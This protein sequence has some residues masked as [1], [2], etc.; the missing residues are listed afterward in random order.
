M[1]T[2]DQD[3]ERTNSRSARSKRSTYN[4]NDE[5]SHRQHPDWRDPPTGRSEW[6][7]SSTS[8]RGAL[9]A[10]GS[11][12]GMAIAGCL[13]TG[14]SPSY[15][16]TDDEEGADTERVPVD[17]DGEGRTAEEMTAA[18]ALADDGPADG[19]SPLD[20]ITLIDHEFVLE[21]GY[22]GSTVQGTLEN[23]GND[24]LALVEIRVR[25][26]DDADDLLG[27]YFRHTNDLDSGSTWAFTVYVLESPADIAA[28]DIAA[29]GTPT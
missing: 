6:P 24:R 18:A 11:I 19:V 17:V 4:T 10:V 16:G 29:L 12:A 21:D 8:R 3:G 14:T 23:A 5:R 22:Q 13:G 27:A 25:V 9:A 26:Y 20:A 15:G 28:Y 1:A 7:G 2:M